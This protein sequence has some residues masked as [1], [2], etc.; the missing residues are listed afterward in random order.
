MMVYVSVDFTGIQSVMTGCDSR[1][2]AIL[3]L[4]FSIIPDGLKSRLLSNVVGATN[5]DKVN[6][7]ESSSMGTEPSG[8]GKANN[9]DD[10][11]IRTFVYTTSP[12]NEVHKDAKDYEAPKK[13]EN[14]GHLHKNHHL[15]NNSHRHHQ[16]KSP[17]P[18]SQ[19]RSLNDHKRKNG[20]GSGSNSPP[21][22]VKRPRI[23][24]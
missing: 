18:Q 16:L 11:P 21:S 17:K 12:D 23:I 22:H 24:A 8:V 3:P 6:G 15:Y 13:R 9:F 20:K 4:G 7:Q 14:N 1:N 2:L 5:K 10:I 19:S